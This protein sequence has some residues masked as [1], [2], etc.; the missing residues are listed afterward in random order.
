MS[1]MSQRQTRTFSIRARE[2]DDDQDEDDNTFP[3]TLSSDAPVDRGGYSEVLSHARGAIN[4]ARA[5]LPLLE[6]HDTS[7]VN[8]GLIE[9]LRIEGGKLRGDVK[10]GS[11]ARAQEI[12]ADVRDR[13]VRSLSVGYSIDEQD[14]DQNTGTVTAKRWTPME[15]SVVSVPADTNAQFFRGARPMSDEDTGDAGTL[16]R[17]QRQAQR[18]TA[19]AELDAA[20]SARNRA[21]EIALLAQRHGMSDRTAGWLASGATVEAVREEILEAKGTREDTLT[22][23]TGFDG[24]SRRGERAARSPGSPI[25]FEELHKYSL[26]RAIRSMANDDRHSKREAGFELEIS[27]AMAD[28]SDRAPKGLMVPE[29]V[30]F[31]FQSREARARLVR[32]MS[33]GTSTAGGDLVATDLLAAEFIDTLNNAAQVFALGARRLD[34]LV[35]NVTV[36]RMTAGSTVHWIGEAGDYGDTTPAFDQPSMTPHDLSARVD[37]T[38]RLMIQSTPAAEEIVRSDLALRINIG[39]DLAAITGTGSSNQPTG[40]LNVSGIGSYAMGTNGGA[41]TWNAITEVIETLASNNGL[42]GNL[43][44]LTNGA[45]MGTLMRTEKASGYPVFCWEAGAAG[46][47]PDEGMVGGYKALVS[48]NVPSTLTKG[49]SS[50]DCSAMIFGNWA[51]LMIGFW[52]GIDLVVDP[53][54]QSQY[55]TIRVTAIQTLDVLTRHPLSFVAV[56]DLLTT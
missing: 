43:G 2:R 46:A 35:G 28:A 42:R 24:I 51:D 18:R 29:E 15:A 30:I 50:G 38:R 21:S 39:I 33:V 31:G 23:P 37:I 25:P 40:L 52:R 8:L 49:T 56:Q 36:P 4:L 22:H 13:I 47:R 9:N 1:F 27:R 41:P 14:Y 26:M 6:G 34:G 3:A 44:W 11:S 20:E 54:S 17:S 55:G 53:Y 7:R 19:A 45:V 5:P 48:N 10:F 16:S 12:A 32:E